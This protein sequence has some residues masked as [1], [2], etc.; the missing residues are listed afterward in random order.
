MLRLTILAWNLI[1][2]KN[3]SEGALSERLIETS[4]DKQVD[5]LHYR[6]HK[7]KKSFN[8]V[9]KYDVSRRSNTERK[10]ANKNET[11]FHN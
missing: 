3:R 1:L 8:F 2:I 6:D 7:S 10:K 4:V 5:H 11:G 9:A